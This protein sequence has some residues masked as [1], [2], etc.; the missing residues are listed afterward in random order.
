MPRPAPARDRLDDDAGLAVLGEEG[1]HARHVDRA[2]GTRQDRR[3]VLARVGAGAG[4]VAEQIELLRRGADE[5]Q[6]GLGTGRREGGVLRQEAVARMHG[7]AAR[8]AGRGDDAG[9]VEIG[10]R[11]ASRER[12]DLVDPPDVQRGGVVLRMDA[13]GC[14]TEFGGGLGDADGDLAAVG[15]QEFL[16]HVCVG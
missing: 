12:P 8:L 9:D 16:E 10:C 2:I 15:D 1:L 11:A 3:P 14:E 4:L 13:H 5:D 7:V 6:P